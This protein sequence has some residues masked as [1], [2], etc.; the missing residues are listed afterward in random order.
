M[1]SESREVI[2]N[3][4]AY[5]HTSLLETEAK[6]ICSDYGMSVPVFRLAG[7]AL[8]AREIAEA[9]GY[10]IVLK[11]V[12][13]N[14]LHKTE[15]RGVLLEL[16]SPA[17][18]EEGFTQIVRNAKEYKSDAE[19]EGVLVQRM[20]PKGLEI[21]IGATKDPQFGPTLMFGLGGV[22]AEILEDVAFRIAPTDENDLREMIHDIRAYPILTGY[23]SQGPASEDSIV[24]TLLAAS[25][26][27]IE[28]NEIYQMD[29]NPIIVYEKGASVIDARIILERQ[30]NS[31]IW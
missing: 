11:I 1:H 28:N 22:F 7:N 19:I 23:R 4:L 16:N 2:R 12:S 20:A 3:A 27:V 29:L 10:P 21:I 18:V 6:M 25:D 14:I 30:P 31:Q 24:K 5:G 26:L 15:A 13:R 17:E 8:E 9:L